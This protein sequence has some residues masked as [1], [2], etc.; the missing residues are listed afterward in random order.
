M[1]KITKKFLATLT[2]KN[3]TTPTN[4]VTPTHPVISTHPV[5]LSHPV[6][7][8]LLIPYIPL[9]SANAADVSYLVPDGSTNTTIDRATNDTPIVN[10]AAPNESGVSLNNFS[11]YNVTSENQILNNYDGD[12]VDTNLGGN[13]AGNTNLAASGEARIIVTQVTGTNRS[14]L[15]GYTEIA[16]GN[17]EL[18]IANPNGINIAGAGAAQK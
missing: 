5:I 10:I 13:I 16:G 7:I 6:I 9:H 11:N 1:K 4:P 8:S 14:N 2:R 17:A 3:L 15:S 18:I 12:F